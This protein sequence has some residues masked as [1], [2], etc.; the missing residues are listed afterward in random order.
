MKNLVAKSRLLFALAII[1][2]TVSC[3]KDDVA[4]DENKSGLFSIEFDNIVGDQTLQFDNDIYSNSKGEGFSITTLKYYISNIK[5]KK[6]DGTEYIVPQEDSYFMVNGRD[7]DSR[8]AKVTVPEGDYTYVSF[9]LG[10][11][12][13]R[14]T[15]PVED[16]KGV[17]SLNPEVENNAGDM[18]WSWNSGYIFFKLEGKSQLISNDSTGD[19]TGN[20][21]F[22]YHIGGF[23][24]YSSPNINNIKEISFDLNKAGIAKVRE[25]LRSNVHLVV[26]I[27]KIFDGSNSFSIV[28]HPT[29]MFSPFSLNIANNFSEMFMHHH[30]ENFEK[31]D[32]DL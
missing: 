26:D 7:K 21:M 11:D 4:P 20:K 2:L 23:G 30:T 22:R 14:S 28:E 31:G 6:A 12:S 29:V 8:F 3:K 27:M 25:G 18:Y 24:G 5:L 16:R 9:V 17:L 10:V 13:L 1:A 32:G 19:P 15:M